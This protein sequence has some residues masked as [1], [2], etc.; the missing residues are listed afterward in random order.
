LRFVDETGVH[1]R[2]V[3]LRERIQSR[4]QIT[5]R[6][7]TTGERTLGAGALGQC[8]AESHDQFLAFVEK[9]LGDFN[10]LGLSCEDLNIGKQ[11]LAIPRARPS[12]VRVLGCVLACLLS[13]LQKIRTVAR[14][15]QRHLALLAAAL[16]T[17]FPMHRR[18]EPLLFAFFT[19]RATQ[20]QFLGPDYFTERTSQRLYH[21]EHRETQ[22]KSDLPCV[23]LCSLW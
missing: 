2:S 4:D 20:G 22:G 19:K 6:E 14:A 12:I 13:C 17:D 16:R 8:E 11:S 9:L 3:A 7:R 21:R 1:Q 15:V 18:A 10:I 23:P 5:V